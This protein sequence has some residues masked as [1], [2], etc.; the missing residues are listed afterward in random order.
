MTRNVIACLGAVLLAS[1]VVSSQGRS[2]SPPPQTPAQQTTQEITLTGCVVAANSAGAYILDNALERLASDEKPR[3]FRMSGAAEDM[4]FM[5][6]LNHRVR[7]VGTA[8]QKTPPA[9]PPDGKIAE[10]DLPLLT[11][12]TIESLGDTCAG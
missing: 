10:R 3:A 7:V 9:P 11:V 8:D 6:V 1:A 4:D 12:K 2:Q 5:Q